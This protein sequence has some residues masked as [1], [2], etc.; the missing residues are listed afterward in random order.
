MKIDDWKK[1]IEE[2]KL[3]MSKDHEAQRKGVYPNR[4]AI[5][6]ENPRRNRA[7]LL[8]HGVFADPK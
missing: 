5:I 8:R 2:G 3:K 4:L 6:T 1:M 7:A